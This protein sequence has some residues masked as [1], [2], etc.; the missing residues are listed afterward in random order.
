MNLFNKQNFI[1]SLIGL[2]LY[3]I[4]PISAENYITE[5]NVQIDR[6][7]CAWFI[8]RYLDEDPTFTFI[9]QGEK[10]SAG[11][12][13]DFFGADYFH[14]GPDCS[15]T[16][17]IKTHIKNNNPALIDINTIVNDVFAWRSGPNSLSVA[18]KKH[19]DTLSDQGKSDAQIYNECFIIFDLLFQMGKG[20]SDGMHNTGK[21]ELNLVT[22]K[23]LKQI[24]SEKADDIPFMQ[25]V[26]RAP[27]PDINKKRFTLALQETSPQGEIQT[28]LH[29]LVLRILEIQ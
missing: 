27:S 6:C 8:T 2:M 14:K 15:Y 7:A 18:I 12:T 13:Y 9:K 11:V 29:A 24:Y 23:T 21:K 16:S 28:S 25:E 19:I 10:P 20:T 3:L 5:K 26:Q 17:F 22:P 4:S 1:S